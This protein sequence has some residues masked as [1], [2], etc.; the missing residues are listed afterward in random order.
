MKYL[1]GIDVGTTSLKAAVFDENAVCKKTVTKDYTLSVSGDRVEFDANEYWK[2]ASEAID[3]LASEFDIYALATDTQCETLIVTDDDG[4]PLRDAIVWLDNR[5]AKEAD[6]IKAK[7]GEE[8]V[9]NITG[10]PEVTATWP[11]SKMLW[12]RENEPF[13]FSKIRK[14]FLLEDWLLYKL[15]GRFIT[16]PTLQSSTIYFDIHNHCWWQD[17]LE[18]VGIDKSILPQIIPCGTLAGE[19]KGIKV[20]TGAI[21]QI[22]GAIGAGV[23]KKGVISEMTGTTMVVF[24]P[25]DTVPQYNPES[26]I[27]CHINYDGKYCLLLWT[28]TAGIALKW[29]KNNLCENYSFKELDNMAKDIEPGS[30]GL[31][32][33]PYLCGATMPRYNPDARGMFYGLTMEHTR[34][35]FVR[36]IL[37]SVACMLKAGLEYGGIDCDEIR[38]MGG[39]A[40][41]PLWCQIKSDMINKKIVTLKNEET[42]CLGS[43]ILAGVA[44]GVFEN[45]ESACDLAVEKNKE[46]TPSGDDYTD[47]Y[48]RY[49]E[50]D[51]KLF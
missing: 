20:C 36:S 13:V 15:T 34:G 9:Y 37:E 43:A 17:M 14:V 1:L 23:V 6:K 40:Q 38:S 31:T 28:P 11:A 45:V 35:H 16:E 18:F 10:Q 49:C 25:T 46:Y 22:A 24:V 4:N 29:F 26:K 32:F 44:T 3:E 5:A 48:R 30:C 50:L 12:I 42:A 51:E 39:G 47:C 41:S 19:Y 33:L 27:P 21:D 2:L 8:T 7:F